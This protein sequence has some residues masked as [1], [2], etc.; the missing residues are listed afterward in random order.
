MLNIEGSL[1]DFLSSLFGFI[2]GLLNSIFRLLADLF[3]GIT[4]NY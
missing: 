3:G 4:I 2:N 1:N